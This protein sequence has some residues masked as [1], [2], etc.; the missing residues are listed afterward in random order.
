VG[1]NN[2][3]AGNNRNAG[4]NQNAGNNQNAEG[5]HGAA[6]RHGPGASLRRVWAQPVRRVLAHLL[7]L[8]EHAE[9]PKALPEPT[10]A[11]LARCVIDCAIY[12]EGRRLPGQHDYRTALAEARAQGGFLWLG[13][14]EPAKAFFAGVAETFD[15]DEF[16]VEQAITAR[17]RPKVERA[18]EAATFVLRT[19]RYVE[20]SELTETSE[21]V[22]TGEI[23]IYLGPDF[24]VTVRHGDPTPIGPI[25]ADLELRPELLAL[26]PWAVAYGIAD[27][28]VDS[29]LDVA[30]RFEADIEM[31][32]E[33]V[34]ARHAHGRIAQIYQL[35]RELME[36][37]RA[38]AP[39]QRPMAAL[40]DDR[41]H[42][43]KEIRRYFRDVN[44]NLLRTVERIS[45]YDD[46]L[47][48]ILSAR[49]AQVTVDQNNDLRKI[50]SWAAIA[51][52]QTAIAGIYGMNFDVMPETNWRYGYPIVLLVML[53]AALTLYRL[54]R[55][56]GWL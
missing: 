8:D 13:L 41:D 47:N 34:F 42:L 28:L 15:L 49:L 38:V 11:E 6:H 46:L 29:Y 5:G 2:Q 26:G 1:G 32:E 9:S 45:A 16:A 17:H 44:D 52:V 55:R 4:S 18:G 31:L 12:V 19:T 48:S 21:V 56:S 24:A 10:E 35:K 43:R 33:Q 37:K 27:R 51:A 14:R 3:N 54:F 25:R 20:H 7:P 53:G 39:L 30:G 22:E 23:V 50:A 40:A 36:F